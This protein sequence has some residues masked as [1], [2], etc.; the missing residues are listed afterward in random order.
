[1]VKKAV[2]KKPKKNEL[3]F[4]RY[5]AWS[6]PKMFRIPWFG[7][8]NITENT[9]FDEIGIEILQRIN[10]KYVVEEIPLPPIQTERYYEIKDILLRIFVGMVIGY[11]I[12]FIF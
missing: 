10:E 1:M 4:H 2:V 3:T 11:V 9:N 12:N 7:I 8:W 5:V 6:F